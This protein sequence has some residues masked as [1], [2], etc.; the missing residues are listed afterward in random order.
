MNFSILK[1]AIGILFFV[2]ATSAVSAKTATC[3]IY[4]S[5]KKSFSGKC[6]FQPLG[7]GSFYLMNLD[8]NKALYRNVMDVTVNVVETGFA[9]VT[10]LTRNHISSRWGKAKREGACWVG[11]DFKICAK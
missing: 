1:K 3:E 10:G 11:N 4:E 7:G 9:E 6:D 2:A 8:T 5:G